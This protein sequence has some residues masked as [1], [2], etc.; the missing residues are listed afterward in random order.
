MPGFVN[1]RSR[2]ALGLFAAFALAGN[3]SAQ[4]EPPLPM[5]MVPELP[6]IP[7]AGPPVV[8]LDSPNT[9]VLAGAG[10]APLPGSVAD[11]YA[12]EL[13]ARE[14]FRTITWRGDALTVF[15]NSLLWEPNIAVHRDPRLQF[16]AL[17]QSADGNNNLD[18]SIGGTMGLFRA[19]ING[20]DLSYQLD[21]FGVVHTRLGSADLQAAD[22]RFGVPITWRRGWWQ[23]KLAYEH[24]SSHL[25]DKFILRTQ[26]E[27]LFYAKD[28]IVAGLGRIIENQFRLYVNIG[29]AYGQQLPNP[30]S[31]RANMSNLAN[32]T[33][34]RGRADIGFE[35]FDREA[36][37]FA[38]TPFLA[39]NVEVR[40]DQNW[41]PN[42]R[43]QAGWLFRNPT[44]RMGNARF[45]VEY[46]NGSMPYGQF[47]LVKESYAAVGFGFDY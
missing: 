12:R 8:A 15:P 5:P 35:W 1:R 7:A 47:Y 9:E 20:A 16:M 23:G 38:G 39:A 17:N 24:T 32:T 13:A 18:T 10:L 29:Y 44:Q 22:Y 6:K 36:T 30:A 21:M 4:T 26:R 41:S 19:D 2:F 33:Q 25:G 14:K 43:A 46:F 27:I 37:G 45:F 28:E 42:L 3:V 34:N 11:D 40:G 31:T